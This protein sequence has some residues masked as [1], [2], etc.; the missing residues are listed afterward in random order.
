MADQAVNAISKFHQSEAHL[1]A[2]AEAT[3]GHPVRDFAC[4][5]LAGGMCNA[6]YRLSADGRDMALKIAPSHDV[7]VMRHEQD[8]LRTEAEMLRL[9]ER[10]LTIPV[11]RLLKW[12]DSE[13]LCAAPFLVM[14]WVEGKALSVLE[15]K[16][17]QEQ[18][19]EIKREVGRISRQ[20]CTLPAPHFGIPGIPESW[21]ENNCDAMLLLVGW[22][23][24]DAQESGVVLPEG[25][26]EELPRR[27]ETLRPVLNQ[28]TAPCHIH[29]D[30]WEGNLM[31]SDGRLTGLVDH[32]AIYWGD[33]LMSHDFHDFG[34]E[35]RRDF[36]EGFGKTTFT[37]EEWLRISIYRL[38]QRLGMMVE[39][40][41][42]GY[43][44]PGQ[45]AWVTQTFTDEMENLRQRM[46]HWEAARQ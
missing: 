45:Y 8:I 15:P 35:P 17:S 27:I 43:E 20:I 18:I 21:R 10:E 33:P 42:R 29:T 46:R 41:F 2:I 24:Q 31:V 26:E 44:D 40:G 9:F 19:G 12:D 32:A 39:R 22:L 6:V 5:E 30:T 1:R 16:P 3:V 36:C 7:R 11:P 14:S 38:W 34:K 28:A 13:T 4:R 25:T 23:L 37:E